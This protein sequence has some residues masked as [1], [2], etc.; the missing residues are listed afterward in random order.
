MVQTIGEVMS[1][2]KSGPRLAAPRLSVAALVSSGQ[3]AAA[4][5]LGRLLEGLRVMP[6]HSQA[7]ITR[8]KTE[9]FRNRTTKINIL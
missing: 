3:Q 5:R 9:F 8:F 2:L 1:V 4:D 7:S 6:L